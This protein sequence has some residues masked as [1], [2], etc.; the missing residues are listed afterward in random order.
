M[1]VGGQDGNLSVE[2]RK[3]IGEVLNE[4]LTRIVI[5]RDRKLELQFWFGYRRHSVWSIN[6]VHEFLAYS[7]EDKDRVAIACEIKYQVYF[8][9]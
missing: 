1:F 7:V 8:L 5:V 9:V 3:S 6:F 4:L 2:T